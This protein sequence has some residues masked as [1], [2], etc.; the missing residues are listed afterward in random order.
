MA[1]LK[2]RSLA[3]MAAPACGLE[4]VP[5]HHPRC[6]CILSFDP[7]DVELSGLGITLHPSE[8]T[9]SQMVLWESVSQSRQCRHDSYA[10][11]QHPIIKG[12]MMDSGFAGLTGVLD[13]SYAHFS[14]FASKADC[15][16]LSATSEPI[17]KRDITMQHL[18]G[19]FTA[20]LATR[21]NFGPILH[22]IIVF[23]NYAQQ[24]LDGKVGHIVC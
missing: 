7:L 24:A 12:L 22:S 8:V 17:C 10:H 6:Q 4:N 19:N 2:A 23:S 21:I 20:G 11:Y 1:K 16:N 13:T 3:I 18:L 14:S 15:G 5:F 9:S